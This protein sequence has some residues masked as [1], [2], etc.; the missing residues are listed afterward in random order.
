MDK[1]KNVDTMEE[2]KEKNLVSIGDFMKFDIRVAE[3][4]AAE[5]LEKS[6]KLMKLQ[7]TLGEELGDRQILAG[8]AKFYPAEELIGKKIAVI[9]NLEP[10]KLAGEESQGMLMAADGSDGEIILLNPESAPAGS[11][12]C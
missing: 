4:L 1:F 10:A 5:K 12:I 9:A 11:K 2:N 8:I 6:N 3:I 7:V